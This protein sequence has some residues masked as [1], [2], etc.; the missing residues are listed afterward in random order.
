MS[1]TWVQDVN[2]NYEI[3]SVQHFLQFINDGALGVD[4]NPPSS[5]STESFIQTVDID[6]INDHAQI[7]SKPGVFSGLYDGNYF[8]ISNWSYSA[9]SSPFNAGLFEYISG[10]I[11]R[12]RLSGVWTLTT[13]ATVSGFITG[14]LTGS[15]TDLEAD[16]SPGTA[17]LH[18]GVVN[19][20]PGILIGLHN[21]TLYGITVKGTITTAESSVGALMGVI[22]GDGRNLSVSTLCR[23]LAYFPN[24]LIGGRYV[25][26]ICGKLDI[27]AISRC[28]NAMV[29]N[30]TASGGDAGGLVGIGYGT[31]DACVNSMIGNINGT[32]SG[33]IIGRDFSNSTLQQ[34]TT[35]ALNYMTGDIVGT[36]SGGY[37]GIMDGSLGSAVS[38]TIVAMN[39]NVSDVVFGARDYTPSV[40]EIAR[41]ESFGLIYNTNTTGGLTLPTDSELLYETDFPDLP[42]FTLEGTDSDGT[43]YK[44]SFIYGNLSSKY[45]TYSHLNIHKANIVF[46]IE[47]NFGLDNTSTSTYITYS[48]LT[49]QSIFIPSGLTVVQTVALAINVVFSKAGLLV[50]GVYDI[51]DPNVISALDQNTFFL[52]GERV[53]V[54][55]GG[56][57]RDTTFVNRGDTINVSNVTSVLAPF[58][59]EI[60]ASQDIT[61]ELSDTSTVVATFDDTLDTV[62]ILG[63]VYSD[64]EHLVLDGKK[65][66][67]QSI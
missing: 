64:R 23:N 47:T 44:W 36:N 48:N 16:F 4:V 56:I 40:F 45:P 35:R 51:T 26:G 19:H 63:T 67:I 11:K 41:D 3:S 27:G 57:I 14:R 46:P 53:R 9:T 58:D 28:L 24:G 12:V 38:K 6:L 55:L 65:V 39:G 59:E 34:T 10:D 61:L 43:E 18:N 50:D 22:F 1:V 25:G 15:I 20:S 29:G 49:N 60:V 37:V 62:T 7:I 21:G 66:T 2:G 52:T 33:G 5:Y 32:N 13:N 8:K 54:S 31:L 17:F 42:Y 30:I